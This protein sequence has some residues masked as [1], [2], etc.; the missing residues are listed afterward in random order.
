MLHARVQIYIFRNV[1][2]SVCTVG[3]H[4]EDRMKKNI[5]LHPCY[6]AGQIYKNR[7]GV[8]FYF[9]EAVLQ[10]CAP[11]G[12]VPRSGE[13]SKAIPEEARMLSAFAQFLLYSYL[14]KKIIFPDKLLAQSVFSAFLLYQWRE[15][16]HRLWPPCSP[17]LR[18]HALWHLPLAK[19]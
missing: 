17:Q 14:P 18:Q 1:P 8:T 12:R 9:F 7:E 4:A 3:T 6:L 2:A 5:Y 11:K 16:R 10:G 13:K 19:L 15:H